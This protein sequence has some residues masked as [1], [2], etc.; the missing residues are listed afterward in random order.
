MS[1]SRLEPTSENDE[2]ASVSVIKSIFAFARKNMSDD[3]GDILGRLARIL[4][5][6]QM[7]H[8]LLA[9]S[10]SNRCKLVIWSNWKREDSFFGLWT[11]VQ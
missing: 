1:A 8:D 3:K 9:Y 11:V 4:L 10:E 2:L 6:I 7:P 5:N